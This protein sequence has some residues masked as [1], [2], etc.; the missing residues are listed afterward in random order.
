MSERTFFRGHIVSKI[1]TFDH[2]IESG[3]IVAHAIKKITKYDKKQA[4]HGL[5]L[6]L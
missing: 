3:Q 5:Y 2:V 6:L 1:L 4:N